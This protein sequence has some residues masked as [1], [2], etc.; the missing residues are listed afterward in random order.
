MVSL[1]ALPEAPLSTVTGLYDIFSTFDIVVPGDTRFDIDLV[2]PTRQQVCNASGLPLSAH[3]NIDDV[4]GTDLVIVPSLWL[5]NDQWHVGRYGRLVDWIR[6]MYEQGAMVCSSCSGSCLIAET[7]L[8]DGQ[9]ATCHWAYEDT[10]RQ[11]FPAVDLRLAEVLVVSGNDQRLIM[12]GSASCWHDLALYLIARLVG[13][14]AANTVAKFFLLQWHADG[15]APYITFREK[16]DHGDAVVLEAQQWMRDNLDCQNPV[17]QMVQRS[18]LPER[19]FKRRFRKATG[20]SPINYIQRLRIEAAKQQL[21][22]AYVAVDEISCSIGYEDPAFFRRL[23]KRTT[24]LTPSAYR[25]KFRLPM[26]SSKRA[27][28]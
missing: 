3:R 7:G 5:M 2:A 11:N 24:G 23:F 19:S 15:Q 9:V 26:V 17:E 14:A 13:P 21:E 18:G 6:R 25:R 27:G 1:L 10:Y 22:T 8:L 16:T 4:D 12:S 28:S 20:C